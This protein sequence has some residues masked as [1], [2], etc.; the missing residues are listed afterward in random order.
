MLVDCFMFALMAFIHL[1]FLLS[2]PIVGPLAEEQLANYKSFKIIHHLDFIDI[3]CSV[4]DFNCYMMKCMCLLLMIY[5]IDGELETI[6]LCNARHSSFLFLN[7][8]TE[9]KVERM[10]SDLVH[11]N[12]NIFLNIG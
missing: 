6:S 7:L 2:T 5:H 4:N 11:S 1:F 8:K 10:N 12:V 3:F 9:L